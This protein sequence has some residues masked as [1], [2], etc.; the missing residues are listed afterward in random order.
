MV[1]YELDHDH[2][3]HCM[4]QSHNNQQIV[5]QQLHLIMDLHHISIDGWFVY[6]MQEKGLV[7]TNLIVAFYIHVLFFTA[8]HRKE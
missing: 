4:Y 8:L 3:A 7:T 1:F 6:G 5:F 2:M